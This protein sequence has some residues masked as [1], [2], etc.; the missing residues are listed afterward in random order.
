MGETTLRLIIEKEMPVKEAALYGILKSLT[1]V[2]IKEVLNK[3]GNS[4]ITRFAR[5]IHGELYRRLG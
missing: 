2:E 1:D 5:L 4:Y 3:L